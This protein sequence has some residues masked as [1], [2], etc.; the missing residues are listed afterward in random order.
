MARDRAALERHAGKTRSGVAAVVADSLAKLTAKTLRRERSEA[1]RG[2]H[3][4][5]RGIIVREPP[6]DV[7]AEH[8]VLGAML[9]GPTIGIDVRRR[10]RRRSAYAPATTSPRYTSTSPPRSSAV[11]E[12]GD[13]VDPIVVADDSRRD[14]LLDTVG[15]VDEL[16]ALQNTDP[17][18]VQRRQARR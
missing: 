4:A 15:G 16:H 18:G 5:G 7:E 12:Q 3:R 13:T 11:H 8:G 10:G 2:A 17:V 14:G 1:C 6:G 9:L